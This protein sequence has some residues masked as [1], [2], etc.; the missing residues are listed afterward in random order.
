M[1]KKYLELKVLHVTYANAKR[2][3]FLNIYF[4]EQTKAFWEQMERS[5]Q[6]L[7]KTTPSRRGWCHG[8]Y[9]HHNIIMTSSARLQS[10]LSIFTM[11][12]RFW[13]FIIS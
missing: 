1:S 8:A 13:M 6:I 5:I 3:G 4:L 2:K 12:I 9:N 7:N 11:D 10:I